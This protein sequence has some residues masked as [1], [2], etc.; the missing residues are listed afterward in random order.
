MFV[1]K[2]PADILKNML[3]SARSET[4]LAYSKALQETGTEPQKEDLKAI[5]MCTD[6]AQIFALKLM[7]QLDFYEDAIA[8]TKQV[9][10]Q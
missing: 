3:E 2:I 4:A 6:I 7:K 1:D 9:H 8:Q 10:P 5:D